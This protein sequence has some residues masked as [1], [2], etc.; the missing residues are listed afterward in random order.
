[1]LVLCFGLDL[2]YH[3]GMVLLH[4]GEVLANKGSPSDSRMYYLVGNYSTKSKVAECVKVAFLII[5]VVL[6]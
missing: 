5:S 4:H 2:K 1:M 3:R 6:F